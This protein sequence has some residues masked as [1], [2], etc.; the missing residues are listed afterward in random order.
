MLGSI[1]WYLASAQLAVKPANFFKGW[2]KFWQESEKDSKQDETSRN[3]Q[4]SFFRRK[5]IRGEKNV[6]ILFFWKQKLLK[7]AQASF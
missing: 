4:K 2:K 5:K 6:H 1:V 7:I 3:D